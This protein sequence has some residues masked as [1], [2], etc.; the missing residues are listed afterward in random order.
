MSALHFLLRWVVGEK[1]ERSDNEVARGE[2]CAKDM[3]RAV[4]AGERSPT[5]RPTVGRGGEQPWPYTQRQHRKEVTVDASCARAEERVQS[6]QLRA[7]QQQEEEALHV[8][9]LCCTTR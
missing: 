3:M 9:A 5:A 6:V 7:M 4:G 8:G 1:G 2:R